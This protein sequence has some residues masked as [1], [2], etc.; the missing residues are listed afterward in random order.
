LEADVARDGANEK[1]SLRDLRAGGEIRFQ[2]RE[3]LQGFLQYLERL[4][5]RFV[6]YNGRGFDIPVVKYRAMVHQLQAP[7]LYH[8]DY[9]YRYNTDSHCDLMEVL[10]DFGASARLRLA[11]I[12][13]AFGIPS[14]IGMDG[15]EVLRHYQAG[16]IEEIRNYC[17]I[18]VV[19]TY[20]VYLRTMFNR[21]TMS[22][23]GYDQAM[24]Q[25][26][27]YLARH[28]QEKQHFADFLKAWAYLPR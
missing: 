6:T 13:S 23:D 1:Y 18:D 5:P 15:S 12:C 28:G 26:R 16:D 20:L 19:N 10:S 25:L 14:K 24:L 3:L 21:G 22:A 17:E 7:L 11:D 2:E 4:R 8:P 27:E 9:S